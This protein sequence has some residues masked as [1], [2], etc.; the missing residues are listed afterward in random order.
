MDKCL[1]IDQPDLRQ[2]ACNYP[3]KPVPEPEGLIDEWALCLHGCAEC[4]LPRILG[5]AR[6]F[7]RTG[8]APA[9]SRLH[10]TTGEHTMAKERVNPDVIV[11]D[12]LED[13]GV[14]GRNGV[15]GSSL[16]LD[17]PDPFDRRVSVSRQTSALRWG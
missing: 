12:D 17:G 5:R 16:P 10:T 15:P 9:F 13:A 2:P 11:I 1:T 6:P 3:Q 7:R 8:R 14:P 4:G